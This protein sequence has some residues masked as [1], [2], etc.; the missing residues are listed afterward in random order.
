MPNDVAVIVEVFTSAAKEGLVQDTLR[1]HFPDMRFTSFEQS[2]EGILKARAARM[3]PPHRVKRLK[4]EMRSVME[5]VA[6][7]VIDVELAFPPAEKNITLKVTV[8]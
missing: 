4:N 7:Q 1:T 3:C 5:G 8:E 2:E 6:E